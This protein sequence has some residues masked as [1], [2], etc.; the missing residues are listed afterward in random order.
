MTQDVGLCGAAS[1]PASAKRPPF[2]DISSIPQASCGEKEG[3]GGGKAGGDTVLY[4]PRGIWF[5]PQM[6]RTLPSS[7][8]PPFP[9]RSSQFHDFRR[10]K[11]CQ[12]H[13]SFSKWM[14]TKEAG[15]M[16]REGANRSSLNNK[17]IGSRNRANSE[18]IFT[19]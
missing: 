13:A 2:R 9:L 19:V 6:N 1:S 11:L 10:L 15:H 3:R 18:L 8:N 5:L 16:V 14:G 4:S 12:G 7:D 17:D